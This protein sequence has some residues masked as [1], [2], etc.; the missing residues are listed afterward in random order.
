MGTGAPWMRAGGCGNH[1][2]TPKAGAPG[3]PVVAILVRHTK[4]FLRSGI[5]ERLLPHV[6]R[7]RDGSTGKAGEG[8]K[9]TAEQRRSRRCLEE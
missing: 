4:T 7:N 8:M 1:P 9:V 5:W 2:V 6:H 3:T